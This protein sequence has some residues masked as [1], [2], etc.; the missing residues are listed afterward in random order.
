M[1][2]SI[3][4]YGVLAIPGTIG[5][6]GLIWATPAPGLMAESV[7]LL[8]ENRSLVVGLGYSSLAR[9]KQLCATDK[10]EARFLRDLKSLS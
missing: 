7:N 5:R 2:L 4:V 6:A 8:V 9:Y 1:K 3:V 10:I